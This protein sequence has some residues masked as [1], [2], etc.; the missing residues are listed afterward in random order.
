MTPEQLESLVLNS[1]KTK[2]LQEAFASLTEK[3]R[4]ALSTTAS[5]LKTQINRGT[6]NKD[7]SVELKR[8]LEAKGGNFWNTQAHS[9]AIIAVFGLCPF[10]QLKKTDIYIGNNRNVLQQ[11][12]LDRKPD[13][14]DDWLEWDLSEEFSIVDFSMLRTWIREGICKKPTS[15]GYIR[16]F[17]W[18]L[19]AVVQRDDLP[20]NPP[21]TEQLL[22]EPDMLEDVWR[23]FEVENQAFNTEG[24]LTTNAPDNYETWPDALL[25][26][27]G[28]GHLDRQRLLDASLHGLLL[29]VKQ[30]QLSGFHKF[31]ARLSP[32]KEELVAR[33]LDYLALLS[34]RVGHVIKFALTMAGQMEKHKVL[35]TNAF[36]SEV[37]AVFMHEAKGNAVSAMRLIKR[38]IK[39]YPE[40]VASGL[41]AAIEGLKHVNIDVQALAMEVIEE[42]QSAI[43]EQHQD[44]LN[45]SLNFVT[46]VIK[47]RVSALLCEE[48]AHTIGIEAEEQVS[49]HSLEQSVASLSEHEQMALGLDDVI[50]NKSTGF[51]APIAPNILQHSILPTLEPIHSIVDLDDLIS[52]VS[53]AV[54][55]VDDPE[56]VE[57]VID[58]I[59]RL[60]DQRPKDFNDKVAP[61]LKRLESGDGL[62]TTNGIASGYGGIR[63]ALADLLMTWL[64]GKHYISPNDKYYSQSDCL[65]PLQTRIRDITE[66]VARSQPQSLI[67]APT[68]VG[69]W[70]DP[71]IWIERIIDCEQQRATFDRIDFCLSFLRL[72]TDNRTQAREQ[73]SR[74][75]GKVQRVVDFALGG[76][77]RPQADDRKDYDIWISAARGRDPNANWAEYFQ[78]LNLQDTWPD[79]VYPAIYTWRAYTKE[80]NGYKSSGMDIDITTEAQPVP[81]KEGNT[82][83]INSIFGKLGK[84]LS[85]FTSTDWKRIPCAALNKRNVLKYSWSTDIN[86]TWIAQ[87]LACQWPLKPES[88]YLQG[89]DQM[90]RR[91]DMDSSNWEPSHGFFHGLFEKRR[92]WQ[93]PAHLLLCTG[94]VGKDADARGLAIDALI[95][96]IE[97]GHADVRLLATILTKLSNGGWLKLN[98]LSENL[99]QVAQVSTVHAWAVS[100]LIQGW[101]LH[102]NLQQHNMFKMLEVLFEVQAIIKQPIYGECLAVLGVFKGSSKT[103]KL[104]KQLREFKNTDE[105]FFENI[106]RL[107]IKT[108]IEQYH[109]A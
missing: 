43:I 78:V 55:I 36:L 32:T 27:S 69:G 48:G 60:C 6:A 5:K 58:G 67:G 71:V 100:E 41:N 63:L 56:L 54:E 39:K 92:P 31:H 25:K 72:T 81:A 17:A 14:L 82:G 44:D 57:R 9:N 22:V 107:A 64:S 75:P 74:L 80:N 91:I 21:I 15:D 37:T 10:S 51:L 65:I 108:R 40:R 52:T 18:T 84:V 95:E 66:R 38:I 59:S 62:A 47:P 24:W 16:M 68:H 94:L 3:E 105:A 42:F 8:Y 93:E 35:D 46:A 89:V 101:L 4:K 12:I 76:V 7:A 53:H 83:G 90:V 45:N 86:T 104:A 29:D 30:N 87:W 13:W 50:H 77:V 26:L 109:P 97:Y 23:L 96:G 19:M 70:I 106:R 61:L 88:V 20:S 102:S 73:L 49:Q 28:S 1:G 85:S 33:Q 2:K 103:A 34:H 99:L 98:R 79:S 11:V